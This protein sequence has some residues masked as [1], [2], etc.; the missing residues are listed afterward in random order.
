MKREIVVVVMLLALVWITPRAVFGS[1]QSTTK[2]IIFYDRTDPKTGRITGGVMLGK[3]DC[4]CLQSVGDSLVDQERADTCNSCVRLVYNGDP[5]GKLDVIFIA[6]HFYPETGPGS[7]FA[8]DVDLMLVKFFGFP[9][10]ADNL[11]KINFYRVDCIDPYDEC[12]EI[13]QA[14]LCRNKDKLRALASRCPGYDP[15]NNDQIVVLFNGDNTPFAAAMAEKGFAYVPSNKHLFMIH[16]FGHSFAFLGDEYDKHVSTGVEPQYPNCASQT[17]GYTCAEKWGDLIGQGGVGCRPGCGYY[18]WYR[19]TYS[20]C[21]MRDETRDHFCPVCAREVDNLLSIYNGIT[22]VVDIKPGSCPNALNVKPFEKQ[23]RKDN[24]KQGGVLPVAVLGAEDFNANDIDVAS[25][26]L[27]GV[28]PLRHEYEDVSAPP[29]D[30]AG[31]DCTA[32]G[33][34]GYVDLTLKFQKSEVVA[35][36]GTVSQGDV[37]PVTLTGQLKDGRPFEATDCVTIVNGELEGVDS[38]VEKETV[39]NP[40]VPNPFNPTTISFTLP[41]RARVTLSIY[42]VQ[43]RTVRT[44]VDETGSGGYQ[45]RVW[46]GRDA[47]GSPV[48]SGVYFYR[49]TA[50]NRTLTKKMVVLR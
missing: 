46:D 4:P 27:E 45:E 38:F 10:F 17:P 36:L 33:P 43:G 18:N 26:R 22:P 32:A 19:P 48:S 3:D 13:S 29:A 23:S 47:A 35:A 25:L 40:A 15:Q 31:C 37:V 14:P 41:E 11:T 39:L 1:S 49:L 20:D 28:T 30:R 44:L 24:G 42:D 9:Q 16:E 8:Q 21:M 6:T 50:G 34:D 12:Y 7:K 2:D 5:S